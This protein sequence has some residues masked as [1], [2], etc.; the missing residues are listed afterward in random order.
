MQII[1]VSHIRGVVWA[2]RFCRYD[3]AVRYH[4]QCAD[5][6]D[7]RISYHCGGFGPNRAQDL[8]KAYNRKIIPT[9]LTIL[10]TVLGLIPFLFDGRQSQFW[11]SFAVGVMSGML[12]SVISIVM[13]MPVF[14]PMEDRKK[15]DWKLVRRIGGL[16][17]RKDVQMLTDC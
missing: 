12:F 9:M 5:L 10:S 6:P 1:F 4:G 2:G 14:F 13:V 3:Y 17:K 15:R 11:F 8:H 16:L 7:I